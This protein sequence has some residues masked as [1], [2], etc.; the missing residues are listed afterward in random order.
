MSIDVSI[1]GILFALILFIIFFAA[2]VLYLAFRIKETFREEKRRGILVVKIAFLIGI[3]FLAGGSFYFFAR[4]LT[5]TP[6]TPPPPSP[7]S[8][9]NEKPLLALTISYPS[10][11][12]MNTRINITFTITNPTD[13]TA[14]GVVIQTNVLFEYFSIISSTHEVIGNVLKIGDVQSG[15]TIS[16]LEL[17]SPNRPREIRDIITL[18][19]IEMSEPITQEISISVSGGP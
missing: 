9:E 4:T 19:F 6:P 10:K 14:H 15:A 2:I 16:S 13:Y 11:I 18:S 12:K 1:L 8:D 3:L 7:P 17:T 5:P